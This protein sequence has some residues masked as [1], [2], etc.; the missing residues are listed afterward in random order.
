MDMPQNGIVGE[1]SA[2]T[3]RAADGRHPPFI[4]T[5]T[6]PASHAAWPEGT[7]M[8]KGAAPGTVSAG[9][10]SDGKNVIGVLDTAVEAN[11]GTGNVIIHGSCPA[12]TLKCV[13]G[14]TVIAASEAQIEALKGIGIYV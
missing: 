11:E 3:R 5:V 12:E 8:A 6:L 13:D 9:V 1:I 4:T 2:S 10:T 7:L 14:A